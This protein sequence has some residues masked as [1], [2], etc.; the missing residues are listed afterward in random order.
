MILHSNSKPFIMKNF[1]E[2]VLPNATKNRKPLLNEMRKN[3]QIMVQIFGDKSKS[4]LFPLKE[5][6]TNQDDLDEYSK[7][8]I[9][10]GKVLN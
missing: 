8:L 4:D 10:L 5:A 1:D 7:T 3:R 6:E 2:K 9:D